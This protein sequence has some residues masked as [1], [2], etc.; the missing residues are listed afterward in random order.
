MGNGRLV[1]GQV[2]SVKG[3]AFIEAAQ[4]LGF[5]KARIFFFYLLPLLTGPL[6][7]YRHLTCQRHPH[8]KRS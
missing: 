8:R 2:L 6:L 3:L 5:S 4:T 1:R 7:V